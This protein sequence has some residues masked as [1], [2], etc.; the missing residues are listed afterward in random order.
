MHGL[1]VPGSRRASAEDDTR[2]RRGDLLVIVLD[3][4]FSILFERLG[5]SMPSHGR[6]SVS[7]SFPP[8]AS[9]T[10]SAQMVHDDI[11]LDI[12]AERFGIAGGSGSGESVLLR[13]LVGPASTGRGGDDGGGNGDRVDRAG[14]RARL[15]GVLFQQG[16]LFSSL[17]VAQNVML[18]IREHTDCRRRA[19]N[20]RRDEAGAAGVPA[21]TGDQVSHRAL[22]RDGEARGLRARARARS[23]DLFL[24]EPTS[25]LDP[26]TAG[27]I[28]TMIRELNETSA[29]PWSS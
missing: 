5:L 26:L 4:L 28:D 16:A 29:S 11:S 18:P 20:H 12:C 27:A 13:T 23:E 10:A 6:E 22:R 2:R 25:D 7:P 24:D 21:D 8:R 15:I 19:G 9:S 3:A 14:E 1:R 17:S